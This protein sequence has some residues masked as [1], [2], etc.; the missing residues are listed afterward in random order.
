MI[1]L[2]NLD[3]PITYKNN[4]I[5]YVYAYLYPYGNYS[6]T[7]VGFASENKYLICRTVV[8]VRIFFYQLEF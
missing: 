4:N 8:K 3:L 1:S 5:E 2:H 7:I 6:N